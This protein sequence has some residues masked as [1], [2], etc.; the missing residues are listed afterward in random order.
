MTAPRALIFA[1]FLISKKR[2]F[3]ESKPG[4][5]R[6]LQIK[7]KSQYRQFTCHRWAVTRVRPFIKQGFNCIIDLLAFAAT[8]F[9][10]TLYQQGSI[11]W[12][13]GVTARAA[14]IH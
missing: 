13:N 11:D 8:I 6:G 10:C 2:G 14:C 7:V 5:F 12:M 3:P 9:A 4:L 1:T